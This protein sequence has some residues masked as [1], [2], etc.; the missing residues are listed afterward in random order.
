MAELL[1][2]ELSVPPVVTGPRAVMAAL[3][4]DTA[5]ARLLVDHWLAGGQDERPMD[6]E[7][8][9]ET[10][11]LAQVAV[12]VGAGSA[13]E[14]LYEQLKPYADRFCVEGIGAAFTGSVSWYLA[15]LA[16]FLG[17]DGDAAR[18]D[19]VARDA[20]RRVGLVGEP[21]PLAA[22]TH[23][24]EPSP[25]PSVAALVF[26]GAG[27]AA[28]F[29]GVTRRLRDSKGL[30]DI[31]VLL[32]RTGTEVHC[33][34]LVGGVD[35]GSAGPVLDEQARRAYEQRIRDLQE[36]IDEAHAANDPVRAERAEAELDALVQQLAEAFGLAG[37]SRQSGAAVE[38]ARSAVTWRI[39]AALRHARE[40]HPSLGR[41]LANSIRTGTWC[42]YRPETDLTW[43]V[44]AGQ[45]RNA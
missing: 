16:R 36:D 30:R 3:T 4:G 6:A 12:H 29:A 27:W 31:A 34:D 10:A 20:H 15:L 5:K 25:D 44:A 7:W 33:L 35:V 22:P 26:E 21:P 24:D 9:P 14:V 18:H 1:G 40:V 42:A 23:A 19:A 37:R 17:R 32:E 13:A 39:R 41:H 28:T 11:Q 45:G 38:R 2:T 8:L 43:T